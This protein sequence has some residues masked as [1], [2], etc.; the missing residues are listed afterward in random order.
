MYSSS[1]SHPRWRARRFVLRSPQSS[2]LRSRFLGHPQEQQ[3]RRLTSIP[4]PVFSF[5]PSNARLGYVAHSF[6]LQLVHFLAHV[7]RVNEPSVTSELT[8]SWANCTSKWIR[9][10]ST[11]QAEPLLSIFLS[12]F[13]TKKEAQQKSAFNSLWRRRS[14]TSWACHSRLLS[15]NWFFGCEH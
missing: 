10:G 11:L 12:F 7:N 9:I 3:R 2:L 8:S 15:S 1:P 13:Y 14:P 6:H 4:F 5:G